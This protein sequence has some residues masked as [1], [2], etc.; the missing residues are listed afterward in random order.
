[1]R[2][3][4]NSTKGNSG[5]PLLSRWKRKAQLTWLLWRA[6]FSDGPLIYDIWPCIISSLRVWA[7]SWA[8]TPMISLLTSCL[9][10]NQRE[11]ILCGPDIIRWAFKKR[12]SFLSGKQAVANCLGAASRSHQELSPNNC[13]LPTAGE[14][15]R[16]PRVQTMRSP[17]WHLDSSLP[18]QAENSMN[19][20]Q[21]PDTLEL[22][23]Q[24]VLT[25]NVCSQLL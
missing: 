15:E 7:E 22:Q 2:W 1:M 25:C 24:F 9:G 4:Q 6:D 8:I 11:I 17:N 23:D 14:R 16:D 13:V 12:H 20:D 3:K 10:V 19:R 21:T 5:K 18:S